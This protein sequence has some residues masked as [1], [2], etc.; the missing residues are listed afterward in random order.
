[1]KKLIRRLVHTKT[2]FQ[3]DRCGKM[4]IGNQY[5][6]RHQQYT[7]DRI[8]DTQRLCRNCIYTESFGSKGLNLRKK[9]NQIEEETIL[10]KDIT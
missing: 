8:P 5:E 1:M 2:K 9:A 3:C 7:P 6:F 10:F 4:I